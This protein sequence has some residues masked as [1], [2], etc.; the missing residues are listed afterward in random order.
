M[1]IGQ[2]KNVFIFFVKDY[3]VLEVISPGRAIHNS[4]AVTEKDHSHSWVL[5][6]GANNKL[7]MVR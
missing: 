6:R 2:N 7:I 1:E 3:T 5:I 4:D